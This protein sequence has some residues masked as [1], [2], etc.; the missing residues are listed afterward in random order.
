MHLPNR[1]ASGFTL[2]ELIIVILVIA[3]LG[4]IAANRFTAV[5]QAAFVT[6][7]KA[8]LRRLSAEQVMFYN[9]RFEDGR[10]LRYGRQNQLNFVPS[11]NVTIRLRANRTGWA[12]RAQHTNVGRAQRCTLFHGDIRTFRPR[13]DEDVITCD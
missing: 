10:R 2:I 4:A 13:G 3:I 5:K 9:T 11:D 1:S 7:M 8:D 6:V 12:A